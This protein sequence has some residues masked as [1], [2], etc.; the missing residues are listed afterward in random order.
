[1]RDLNLD[2]LGAAVD[3]TDF[4]AVEAAKRQRLDAAFAAQVRRE[5]DVWSSRAALLLI[6]V[7][8][9]AMASALSLWGLR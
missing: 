5:S 6:A 7:A 1:M 9:A 3:P 8:I 2:H 4:A